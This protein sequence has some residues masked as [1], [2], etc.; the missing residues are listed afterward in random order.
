MASSMAFIDSTALNVALPALQRDLNVSGA[1]LMWIVNAYSLFLSALLLVGG[2]LGDHYGRK[3]VFMWGIGLFSFASLVCGLA[4]SPSLLICSRA[5]QGIGG[6]MMVPGSLSII[7]AVFPRRRRGWAIGLWSMFSA[8]TTV[9][10]PILGGW[11]AGEG[12]WRAIFFINIPLSFVAL[13]AL[14]LKVDES[15]DEQAKKLDIRGSL[16]ATVALFG[17]TYGFIEAPGKGFGSVE[18]IA[19]LTSGILALIAFLWTEFRSTHPMMPLNLFRSSTFSS[20]NLLTLFV[21]AA[22]GGSLFFVP[23]NLVQ[24]QGYHEI[25]TGMAIFPFAILIAALSPL[26]GKLVDRLGPRLPL[27]VGPMVTGAGFYLFTMPGLTDGPSEYWT[28]FFPAFFL[29][30]TGMGI[31]VAPLTSTVMGAVPEGRTGIASGINNTMARTAGVLAIA[32]LGSLVLFLFQDHLQTKSSGLSLTPSNRAMLLKEAPKL[33]EAKPP[34][35]L[36]DKTEEK[37]EEV[38]NLSFIE[39]FNITCYIAAG[40]CWLGS[41]TAILFVRNDIDTSS[42]IELRPSV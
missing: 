31:T 33:A 5:L 34:K 11:L 35:G 7:S 27:I 22:L 18:I 17:L 30:G 26:S 36:N 20:A 23:L 6:A 9:I 10:G 3:K 39:A 24:V 14:A 4:A 29:L 37:I 40:L 2:S 32:V 28:T 16:L 8:M 21:Y 19:S 15:K 1:E 13:T 12:L 38:I 42:D 41:L 25:Q